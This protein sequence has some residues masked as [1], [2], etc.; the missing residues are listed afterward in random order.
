MCFF[1]RAHIIR[2]HCENEGKVASMADM[3]NERRFS[4]RIEATYPARLRS[5]DIK[6][7]PFK[8]EMVLQN[9]SG[10]GVYLHLKRQVQEGAP[11]FLAVWLSVVPDA[12]IPTLRLAARGT[13][14]R[15]DPQPDG[16]YG[17]AIAFKRRR[18]L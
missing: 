4:T 1:L 7:R 16:S 13:V 14:V 9:L 6:D 12:S 15:V 17:V 11:V 18:V 8:E 2:L 3:L 10:G 5:V